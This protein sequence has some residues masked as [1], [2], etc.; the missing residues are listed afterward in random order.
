LGLVTLAGFGVAAFH[1][2]G[3]KTASFFTGEKKVRGMSWFAVGGNLGFALGPGLFMLFYGF[4]KVYGTVFFILPGLLLGAILYRSLPW[5]T[6]PA[7]AQSTDQKGTP[8][9]PLPRRNLLVLVHLILIVIMRSWIQMGL[10]SFIP[11]Y[12]INYLRGD[13]WVA[14]RL[15]SLYLLCGVG[16]TLFAAPLADR[17]G[18][19]RFLTLSFLLSGPLLWGFLHSSGIWTL[20]FL[21]VSGFVLIAS[22]SLT[23]VMAQTILPHHLGIASGLMVG[24]A[25][26]TGGIGVTLLGAVSD[27]FGVPAA[28]KVIVWLPWVGLILSLFLAYPPLR[29]KDPASTPA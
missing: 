23:V 25:I 6:A 21:G 14:G 17:I 28:L 15:V 22:F 29:S 1:P 26:G 3:F 5:L 10:V 4:L 2:E 13:P 11:F 12:Y 16:G 9:P 8:A 24:F 27:Y 18:H 7:K 19:K 20:I